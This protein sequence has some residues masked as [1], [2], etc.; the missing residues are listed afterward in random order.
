MEVAANKLIVEAKAAALEA[1]HLAKE[2]KDAE[3]ATAVI[4]VEDAQLELD[5]ATIEHTRIV[6]LAGSTQDEKDAAL[7]VKTTATSTLSTKTGAKT[8]VEGE[9]A[10]ITAAVGTA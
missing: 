10:A 8:T 3:V 9:E 2:A 4:E 7:L 5:N 6:A 1:S